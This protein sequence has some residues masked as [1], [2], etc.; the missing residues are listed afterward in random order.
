MSKI[1]LR[2]F[3]LAS[4]IGMAPG[5]FIS[6]LLGSS[7]ENIVSVQFFVALGAF[8][9]LALVPLIYRKIKKSGGAQGEKAAA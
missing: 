4:F 1:R 5:G 9:L 7:L 2:D 3:A 8:I 6:A